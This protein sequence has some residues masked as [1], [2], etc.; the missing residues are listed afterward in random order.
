MSF[1]VHPNN[2]LDSTSELID[3][4]IV[5]GGYDSRTRANLKKI[6]GKIEE[7]MALQTKDV[8]VKI[9]HKEYLPKKLL[10]EKEISGTP[11][12]AQVLASYKYAKN[13]KFENKIMKLLPADAAADGGGRYGS[14]S[15]SRSRS[16]EMV[17]G[18]GLFSAIL[19]VIMLIKLI[20]KLSI[21][22]SIGTWNVVNWIMKLDHKSLFTL[23]VENSHD[24]PV[25][26]IAIYMF[27]LHYTK[28]KDIPIFDGSAAMKE[29]Y[30]QI[31]M[32]SPRS[33]SKVELVDYLLQYHH[34]TMIL[35]TYFVAFGGC[36][37]NI[38]RKA[39]M[40]RF[41]TKM[42]GTFDKLYKKE[43]FSMRP[44][45]NVKQSLEQDIQMLCKTPMPPNINIKDPKFYHRLFVDL[46]AFMEHYYTTNKNAFMSTTQFKDRRFKRILE[47]L[48]STYATYTEKYPFIADSPEMAYQPP[49]P[50]QAAPAPPPPPKPKREIK[51]RRERK[52]SKK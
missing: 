29:A 17:D 45:I 30:K 40:Q 15:R 22:I 12:A 14:Y 5:R 51:R 23:I 47:S 9:K 37:A 7:V 8:G 24:H 18:D 50:R 33:K 31:I 1:C 19:L 11:S 49:P 52:T 43:A 36:A 44:V 25:C 42:S 41:T 21:K 27:F 28:N 39:C 26:H 38:G 20:I 34:I 35:L 46:I 6:Q 16:H 32:A 10:I 4:L 13:Y 3:I 2:M 48:K